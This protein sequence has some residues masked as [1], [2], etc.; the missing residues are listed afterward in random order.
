MENWQDMQAA[1]I[2]E[3]EGKAAELRERAD[4]IDRLRHRLRI[5]GWSAVVSSHWRDKLPANAYGDLDKLRILQ[6]CYANW[7]HCATAPGEGYW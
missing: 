5:G 3:L 4:G 2:R 6:E 1:I 7:P